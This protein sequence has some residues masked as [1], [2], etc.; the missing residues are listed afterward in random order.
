MAKRTHRRYRRSFHIKRTHR[1]MT[2]VKLIKTGIAIGPVALTSWEAFQSGGPRAAA[3]QLVKSY[4]PVDI[5]SGTVDTSGLITGYGS[6]FGAWIFGKV[7]S[8]VL[9]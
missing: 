5:I 9:R 8:R 4:A 6:A 3:A 7:M 2:A 1:R